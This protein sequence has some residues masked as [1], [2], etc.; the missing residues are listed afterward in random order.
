MTTPRPWDADA[1][2]LKAK[3]FLNHAMDEDEEHRDFDERA[4]WASLALELLAKAALARVSPVLI[5][6]PNEEGNSLLV[7]SGLVDGDVRFMS[8]Q[9]KTLFGRCSKAFKPFNEKEAQA[10]AAARNEYL[11]GAAPTF[12]L[13]PPEAW[14]PR[15]W[16]QVQILVNACDRVLEDLVGND[17]VSVVE[18]YLAKNKK[19]IE[20]RLEML[21]ERAR[22]QLARHDSGQMRAGE[23]AEWSR[24]RPGGLAAGLT[25][26][27][28][29]T[30]PACG[31]VGLLEG[32]DVDD[33]TAN[34]EQVGEDDYDSWMDLTVGSGYFS[35]DRCHLVLD[36][37]E[38]VEASDIP[39]SFDA[40]GEIG[41]FLEPEYGND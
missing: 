5:A 2:L 33:A 31:D 29:Q 13:I 11:H 17:R 10:I 36:S 14:W 24:Y 9:A 4:L 38:L 39:S 18:D 26:S 34:H 21:I 41:D 3:L 32:E 20:H 28:V 35:C 15:Y 23:V 1:M 25:Y 40:I 37:Y 6:A 19:N 7:A 16:A 12:T 27:T 30:C 8:V 22:Q